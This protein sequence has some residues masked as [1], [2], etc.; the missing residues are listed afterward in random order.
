MMPKLAKTGRRG[1]MFAGDAHA[2]TRDSKNPDAA[3]ELLKWVTDKEFGVQH[4]LQTKGSTTL[5]GR[6]DVYADPRILNHDVYT[7]QMQQA[8]MTSV[9]TI[10]EPS[11]G[12][13]NFRA[14][15]VERVRDPAITRIANG[16]AK[17]EPGLLKQLNSELQVILDMPRP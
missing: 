6:P 4:G 5:G 7:K 14:P 12:P 17:A 13:A 10:R 3:F 16:E 15:E 1:G 8:Q 11:T 9:N 2:V